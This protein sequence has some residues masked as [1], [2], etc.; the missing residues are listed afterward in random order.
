MRVLIVEDDSAIRG[1]LVQAL[2]EDGYAVD[3]AGDGD[4][5]LWFAE[6]NDYD[7]IVL[8]WMLP[9]IDGLELLRRV[10]AG[11]RHPAV[12]LISARDTVEDRVRG[13]DV[14]ADDYLVKPFALPELLARV[15]SLLRRHHRQSREGRSG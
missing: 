14:G 8:D 4:E 7:L 12:L 6:A 13:L 9:G 10:R 5:G 1:A 2:H 15:R 11:E 3:S